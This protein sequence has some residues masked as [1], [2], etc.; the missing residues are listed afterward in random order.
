MYIL[1]IKGTISVSEF[2]TE[3]KLLTIYS[4][5]HQRPSMLI[6]LVPA[7]PPSS[8]NTPSGRFLLCTVMHIWTTIAGQMYLSISMSI[9]KPAP[10]LN[11]NTKKKTSLNQVCGKTKQISSRMTK[12]YL[13]PSQEYW[14]LV[15]AFHSDRI[16][17]FQRDSQYKWNRKFGF[18]SASVFE[19]M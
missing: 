2:V 3:K 18:A 13:L 9:S 1:Q 19:E 12:R 17:I 10:A 5:H 15:A 4:R 16:D 14:Q 6:I 8:Q 7:C 11:K